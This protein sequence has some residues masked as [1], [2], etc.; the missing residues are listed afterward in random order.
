MN[1]EPKVMIGLPTMN[2]LHPMLAILLMGWISENKIGLRVYPTLGVQPVD[3]ARNQIVEEFLFG[4]GKDCTHLFFIDSDT[5][6]PQEALENLLLVNKPI[7]SG[8]TPIVD[9]H[10]K[11]MTWYRKWNCILPDGKAVR[12]NT[13]VHEVVGAGGSCLLIRR[14]VLETMEKPYFRFVYEDDNKKS[15]IVSE[16][17]YFI[18]KAK[19]KGFQTFADTSVVC[20][21]W[22][23]TLW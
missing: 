7:A 2:S 15:V 3:N 8:I 14:D 6:P 1:T 22:K 20:H 11:D 23:P 4:E 5:I 9:H 21:H 10:D 16:D 12:P 17:I 18:A 13:G 19:S